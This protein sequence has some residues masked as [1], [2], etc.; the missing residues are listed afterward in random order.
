MSI[1]FGLIGGVL[2][3]TLPP[4]PGGPLLFGG[5]ILPLLWTGA[6]HSLMGIVNPLLNDYIDWPWYVASQLVYGIATSIVIMRSEKIRSLRAATA[7]TRAGRRF[8]RA[9][10]DACWHLHVLP[11]A[12]TTNL[13]GK[14]REANA[15]VMPQEMTDFDQLYATA[16]RRLSWRGWNTWAWAAAERSDVCG[17]GERG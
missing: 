6:N 12:A 7:A 11:A 2:L 13:P 9:G 16:M 17:A 8:R 5:V 3:P 15:F 14:P 10:W 1:G 4:I